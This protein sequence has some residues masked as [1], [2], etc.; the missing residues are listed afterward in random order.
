MARNIQNIEH[1]Q[2]YIIRIYH[3]TDDFEGR[4]GSGVN[5]L[6][7]YAQ[8][9][10]SLDEQ[11]DFNKASLIDI[12]TNVDLRPSYALV[13]SELRES[14][15]ADELLLR[16]KQARPLGH[17][18]FERP[19]HGPNNLYPYE[20]KNYINGCYYYI[21]V[22]AEDKAG[23]LELL[24]E[25]GPNSLNEP[26]ITTERLVDNVAPN[27]D[28]TEFLGD[29]SLV[30]G[31]YRVNL[32]SEIST[33]TA[34]L[35][36]FQER[37]I[38][39][40]KVENNQH[41][42]YITDYTYDQSGPY[43]K[44]KL[45]YQSDL[46]ST[47]TSCYLTKEATCTAGIG[48]MDLSFPGSDDASLYGYLIE[49]LWDVST[50]ESP[51][52]D[53]NVAYQ[54]ICGLSVDV[55][56]TDRGLKIPRLDLLDDDKRHFIYKITPVSLYTTDGEKL[57]D[58]YSNAILGISTFVW[59]IPNINVYYPA[60][61][62]QPKQLILAKSNGD[63]SLWFNNSFNDGKIELYWCMKGSDDGSQ[64]ESSV[65]ENGDLAGYEIQRARITQDGNS[66]PIQETWVTIVS[67]EKE[68][69]PSTPIFDRS[70]ADVNL[71]S[72]RPYP[73]DPDF[74]VTYKYRIRAYDYGGNVGQ[75]SYFN[76]DNAIAAN[77]TTPPNKDNF[78]LKVTGK[79]G[80]WAIEFFDNTPDP[81][82]VEIELRRYLVD[83]DNN[84]I[85]DSYKEFAR[86]P[87]KNGVAY[88]FDTGGS[89][90]TVLYARYSVRGRDKNNNWSDWTA[91]TSRVGSKTPDMAM[92]SY[93][94]K[95]PTNVV[96]EYKQDPVD[97]DHGIYRRYINITWTLP[98][99]EELLPSSDII[100]VDAANK[101][102]TVD[103]QSV[104]SSAFIGKKLRILTGQ[105]KDA[106]FIIEDN[107]G[108]SIQLK[109][110][111]DLSNIQAGDK[112]EVVDELSDL[113]GCIVFKRPSDAQAPEQAWI[114]LRDTNSKNI[115][116]Y[117]EFNYQT[118]KWIYGVSAY[119]TSGNES[120]IAESAEIEI[121]DL[122]P[123]LEVKV[124][125]A[126]AGAG[127]LTFF[128]PQKDL[129]VL[130]YRIYIK[131]ANG[132][133]VLNSQGRYATPDQRTDTM[134]YAATS[135]NVFTLFDVTDTYD[136]IKNY[137]V[138][139][140]AVDIA[141]NV[142]I[143]TYEP[144][145]NKIEGTFKPAG[146]V[147]P[148][149]INVTPLNPLVYR[150]EI[151]LEYRYQDINIKTYRDGHVEISVNNLYAP[152]YPL[153][154]S[155][156]LAY[157]Y[158][159]NQSEQ[160]TGDPIIYNTFDV[161]YI[162]PNT[163]YSKFTLTG[164]KRGYYKLYFY[165]IT[166]DGN[167]SNDPA[168]IEN[169]LFFDLIGPSLHDN[170]ELRTDANYKVEPGKV[171]FTWPDVLDNDNFTYEI[172]RTP[173][174]YFNSS[175]RW[176]T[177]NFFS[178]TDTLGRKL[179]SSRW[180]RLITIYSN[181][182]EGANDSLS[183]TDNDWYYDGT[184]SNEKTIFDNQYNGKAVYAL[185]G[186]DQFGN[187]GTPYFFGSAQSGIADDN[188]VIR[189]IDNSNYTFNL[190]IVKVDPEIIYYDP[191]NPTAIPSV[192]VR[193]RVTTY[194]EIPSGSY[195]KWSGAIVTNQGA[196]VYSDITQQNVN[197]RTQLEIPDVTITLP[198]GFTNQETIGYAIKA[199][200]FCNN[201]LHAF[202]SVLVKKIIKVTSPFRVELTNDFHAFVLNTKGEIASYSGAATKALAFW[203]A[204]DITNLC[205]FAWTPSAGVA[206]AV[207]TTTK[208]N[209]TYTVTSFTFDKETGP[210][211]GYVEVKATYQPSANNPDDKYEATARFKLALLMAG[212]NITG[213][214]VDVI[215]SIITRKIDGQYQ[216]NLLAITAYKFNGNTKTTYS[217][218]TIKIYVDGVEHSTYSQQSSVQFN[219]PAVINTGVKI[220]LYDNNNQLVDEET[221]PVVEPFGQAVYLTASSYTVVKKVDGSYDP[222]SITIT[223]KTHDNGTASSWTLNPQKTYTQNGNTI[224]IDSS[225]FGDI[226][227]LQVSADYHGHSDSLTIIKLVESKP[228]L[229]VNLTNDSFVA[230]AAPGSSPNL[231]G[232]TGYLTVYLGTQQIFPSNNYN[233]NINCE[234]YNCVGSFD[235]D[236]GSYAVTQIT[237]DLDV[238]GYIK[239][240]VSYEGVTVI[241]YFRVAVAIDGTPGSP[242]ISA[243]LELSTNVIRKSK[244]GALDPSSITAW[245]RYYQGTTPVSKTGT[246][247][248]V[249]STSSGTQTTSSA[250]VTSATLSSIPANATS[251]TVYLTDGGFT[252]SEVVPVL[253]DGED[254]LSAVLSNEAHE[255][256]C[257]E[258]GNPLS[259]A[260]NYASGQMFVYKGTLNI[261][262]SCSFSSS[263]SGCQG[264]V[265]SNGHYS[266][267]SMSADSAT[268]TITA[269]YNGKSISKVFTLTKV[270]QGKKGYGY[271][272]CGKYKSNASYSGGL[273]GTRDI[274]EYNGNYY[275]VA[276]NIASTTAIPGTS[277]WESFSASF[278]YVATRLAL[279]EDAIITK[280]L[281]LGSNTE[282]GIIQTHNFDT[283]SAGIRIVGSANPSIEIKGGRL[284][285]KSSNIYNCNI[286]IDGYRIDFI[287]GT[288]TFGTLQS[289][290][291]QGLWLNSYPGPIWIQSADRVALIAPYVLLD[292][293]VYLGG[294]IDESK[295]V[296]SKSDIEA[297]FVA[298]TPP[299][300]NQ[301]S[302]GYYYR[303]A[304]GSIS[305]TSGIG[306]VTWG[307]ITGT[308]S[309]QTDLQ[310]ALNAK[311]DYSWVD[312]TYYSK[313]QLQNSGQASVHWNNITNKPSTY[314]PD[315]HSHSA[316]DLPSSIVYTTGSYANPSWI[317]SLA[318]SKL[319]GVPT[320]SSTTS[321]ILSSTDW[322][323]FNNKANATHTHTVAN[324]TDIGTYYYTKTDLQTSE[325]ALVH[326]DNIINRPTTLNGYDITDAVPTSR[327]VY[328]AAPLTG[329][330]DLSANR[331]IG[332]SYTSPLTLTQGNQLTIISLPQ[333]LITGV[334]G[335]AGAAAAYVS[336][337]SGG[338]TTKQLYYIP[339]TIGGTT[340]N[341]LLA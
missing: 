203:G 245:Y 60:V 266:V 311:A 273:S 83:E 35:T 161:T 248:F 5:N 209:D 42:R 282:T 31:W 305:L 112:A 20:F 15:R 236:D 73:D 127:S 27:F 93:P 173:D 323:T 94:P 309:N 197:S 319:T 241:K 238:G 200:L 101:L 283:L 193:A 320:A 19:L 2:T 151:S 53:G 50:D 103:I 44:F 148:K 54:K 204:K 10:K 135:T 80:A 65:D 128:W 158:K 37:Y 34:F 49:R 279:A 43:F 132:K 45:N 222:S 134:Y 115:N 137:Q 270:K 32:K 116:S 175:T 196:G 68:A 231:T 141:N 33:L 118:G 251:I 289:L 66:D 156:Q 315:W 177:V 30:D 98:T 113:D 207:S 206:G 24:N 192:V 64:P 62:K 152:N 334:W 306:S 230:H 1:E 226:D 176:N 4:I 9:V 267:T 307:S 233:V 310:T 129:D 22:L 6:H 220:E 143:L 271:R 131:D 221:I 23:N 304:D 219:L 235:T 48:R 28:T 13:S 126:I 105:R 242:A 184:I 89:D 216:Y 182:A 195:I 265:D 223:A 201:K 284:T 268:L 155:I 272:F 16:D 96:A 325:R 74:Y 214:E 47:I 300:Y 240:T 286:V 91:Y 67:S 29:A 277:D 218:G 281:T 198:S 312:S 147:E 125:T 185:V 3:T 110:D 316:G 165:I 333:S 12:I 108:A 275:V 179:V 250:N 317:T 303:N 8:A 107:I 164:L 59:D 335:S 297:A 188:A 154:V 99:E 212:E 166:V 36:W 100:A 79:I 234:Y 77:D 26:L 189:M 171:T 55:S 70:F 337:S 232:A 25:E 181:K 97:P 299:N 287:S 285:T 213:Y 84:Q 38:L 46:P 111:A 153:P 117:Q 217:G 340:Y 313:S 90:S 21:W 338:P 123:P 255:I 290:V 228:N 280:T 294:N 95:A 262:G 52:I 252:D 225:V 322:N 215:P 324:I 61:G 142:S 121:L 138:G 244:T 326:W 109:S 292:S 256:P 144:I 71:E 211:T 51:A 75:W 190:I 293:S 81:Q 336:N 104:Q 139:I 296:L 257:D 224:T 298:K 85:A 199:E 180:E 150:T 330:G 159:Q 259:D 254:A 327:A 249:V 136:N 246:F 174:E 227:S 202:N 247:Q 308:L 102:I 288:T 106:E 82:T 63:A 314:P 191:Q 87:V 41:Y 205:S 130:L 40:F 243:Y 168:I 149:S 329:G 261:T 163:A 291:D 276:E 258:N 78:E 328:T 145:T 133:S 69:F 264:S 208:E 76:G 169:V 183:Y 339:V 321:G 167:I 278:D 239:F 57:A 140:Q 88:Y 86:I 237:G 274:V 295:K 58:D 14:Y 186:V 332:L 114:L 187:R 172:W 194:S 263:S 341:L 260:F 120:K 210:F 17:P 122:V 170:S 318:Y 146:N 72:Y 253:E 302:S 18:D 119:D 178:G 269:T 39:A 301:N 56:Y 7:I 124:T 157:Q 331:T 11:P 162:P 229:T 92:D 160:Y